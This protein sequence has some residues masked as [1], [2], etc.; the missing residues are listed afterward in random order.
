MYS[1]YTGH[2]LGAALSSV[3]F[4][5]LNKSNELRDK[6]KFYNVTFALPMFGNVDL[7]KNIHSSGLEENMFHFVVDRD[8]I[9]S[10]LLLGFAYQQLGNP[11]SLFLGSVV[12]KIAPSL[13]EEYGKNDEEKK[14]LMECKD[15]LM[16]ATTIFP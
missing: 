4:L 11:I 3:A 12:E 15:G 8:L 10:F 1:F 16:E 6:I 9:P 2:S 7:K 13:I 5:L 14:H